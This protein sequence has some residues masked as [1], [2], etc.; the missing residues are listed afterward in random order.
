M[1]ADRAKAQVAPRDNLPRHPVRDRCASRACAAITSAWARLVSLTWD[2]R[3]VR[4]I[5]PPTRCRSPEDRH[6]ARYLPGVLGPRTGRGHRGRLSADCMHARAA[7]G[8]CPRGVGLVG[9]Y[10]G[11]AWCNAL[12]CFMRAGRRL[13]VIGDPWQVRTLPS[14][15]RVTGGREIRRHNHACLRQLNSSSDGPESFG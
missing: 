2:A 8:A 1:R 13:S 9:K 3:S 6:V 7:R 14:R 12:H 15:H 11:K 5:E 10:D 4:R